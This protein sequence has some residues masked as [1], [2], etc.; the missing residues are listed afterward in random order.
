MVL[1][2]TTSHQTSAAVLIEGS[3]SNGKPE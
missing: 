1:V 3:T 2:D